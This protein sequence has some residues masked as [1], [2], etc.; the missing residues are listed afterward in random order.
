VVASGAAED[1]ERLTNPGASHVIDY[2]ATRLPFEQ[3]QEGLATIAEGR[4]HG[5][6]VV[7]ISD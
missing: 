2:T 4:A 7:T 1:A 3:A 6:I 5:K